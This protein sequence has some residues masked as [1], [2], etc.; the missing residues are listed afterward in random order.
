MR[1][2]L[3]AI[4]CSLLLPVGVAMAVTAG[5]K[6]EDKK[7]DKDKE[8]KPVVIIVWQPAWPPIF[9]LTG[10]STDVDFAGFSSEMEE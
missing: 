7:G 5:D 10:S 2:I 4:L 6:K 8:N 3:T 9:E 1:K